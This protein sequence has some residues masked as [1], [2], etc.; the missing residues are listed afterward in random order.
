MSFRISSRLC[1]EASAIA[2]PLALPVGQRLVEHQPEQPRARRSSACGSRGSSPRGSATS[3]RRRL[4]LEPAQVSSSCRSTSAV[5]SQTSPTRRRDPSAPCVERRHVA[6][7]PDLAVRPDDP[8]LRDEAGRCRPPPRCAS[9]IARSRSSGCSTPVQSASLKSPVRLGKAEERLGAVVPEQLVRREVDVPDP[10]VGGRQREL[11]PPGEPRQLRLAVADQR[12]LVLPR[13]D[14][15]RRP[16]DRR[17]D[18]QAGQHEQRPRQPDAGR[19]GPAALRDR[20]DL[21]GAERQRDPGGHRVPREDRRVA[22]EDLAV[23]DA[24]VAPDERDVERQVRVGEAARPIEARPGRS[25]SRRCPRTGAPC[26]SA[27]TKTGV[28]DDE[29]AAALH[30]VEP[31]RPARWC[32]ARAP[33]PPPGVWSGVVEVVEPDDAASLPSV[34]YSMV[35]TRLGAAA[36]LRISPRPRISSAP[37]R[38]KSRLVDLRLVARRRRRGPAPAGCRRRSRPC[39][40]ERRTLS[41]VERLRAL[42]GCG[43]PRG[44]CSRRTRRAAPRRARPRSPKRSESRMIERPAASTFRSCRRS[45]LRSVCAAVDCTAA[46]FNQP[47]NSTTPSEFVARKSACSSE[48][49]AYSQHANRH[50]RQAVSACLPGP[51]RTS[52]DAAPRRRRRG[53][54]GL[55]AAATGRSSPW[56]RAG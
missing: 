9:A 51:T 54:G 56:S 43:T 24:A 8:V 35:T 12:E 19:A 42:A 15:P 52:R 2:R 11:Q 3:P 1:A 46:R 39:S 44:S 5:T 13:G 53:G 6:D 36:M 21:P 31:A 27:P 28:R 30:Q 49:T 48:P 18:Q 32:R 14:E 47:E 50:A 29:A 33:S 7:V 4:G 16:E 22:E 38:A 10:D 26:V 34:G 23:R 45:R 17:D 41:A 55:T 37:R 20:G 25:P 40:S